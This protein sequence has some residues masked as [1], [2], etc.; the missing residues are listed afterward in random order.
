LKTGWRARDM[1]KVTIKWSNKKFDDV[2][3]DTAESAVTFKTQLW[4][5]TGVPVDRQKLMAKGAWKGVLKDEMG[6]GELKDGQIIMLMGSAEALPAPPAESARPRFIEDMKEEEVAAT[7]TVLPAGLINMGN[8]CYMNSTLQCL[9]A[10]PEMREGL[11]N[12]RTASGGGVPLESDANKSLALGLANMYSSLDLSTQAVQPMEFVGILRTCFPQ[13]AQR[14]RSGGFAQQDAEEFYSTAV[15]ALA[16]QLKEAHGLDNLGTANNLIDALFGLELEETLKCQETD[17]EPEVTKVDLARKLVCNIQGGAGIKDKID[18]LHEGV[19]LGM[20]G[21]IEKR[22]DVLDRDALWAK[23]VKIKRLPRYLCV[24]YMRFYWKATPESADHTGV[25]CKIMRPITY[26]EVFDVFDC[27]TEK[28]QASLRANRDKHGARLDDG[29]LDKKE[30]A[31][32]ADA[33]GDVKM[34]TADEPADDDDAAALKAAMAMSMEPSPA[35]SEPV[36]PGLPDDF[37]GNYE[38]FAIVTHKGRNADGGHYI[39]FVREEGTKWLV[40]D[41]ET[42]SET[43]TEYIMNLKGGG[44][45]HMAYLSFYRYKN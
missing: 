7:G 20:K 35:P 14:G 5:L 16:S 41:D 1:V 44:D 29:A 15:T 9:R 25:K 34:D 26:P 22:S 2:D 21:T 13:F 3:V 28:L 8:T 4:T 33:D 18:H 19:Q 24:Q 38:L 11:R 10:V 23:S 17:A 37:Q 31:K 30:E 36:G 39:S 32:P 42:V 6:L 40:Y 27:C 12:F 43:T 45:E